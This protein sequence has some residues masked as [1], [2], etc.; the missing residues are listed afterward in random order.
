[1]SVNLR[2]CIFTLV[3]ANLH[4]LL[5]SIRSNAEKNINFK[6]LLLRETYKQF[7]GNNYVW[8]KQNHYFWEQ[9]AGPESDIF[10]SI[11]DVDQTYHKNGVTVQKVVATVEIP[12]PPVSNHSYT[13]NSEP[14]SIKAGT[15]LRM[16]S[17][18]ERNAENVLYLIIFI[19][20]RLSWCQCPANNLTALRL[21]VHLWL[22]TAWK[23][24]LLMTGHL[25]DCNAF[26]RSL[27]N[28]LEA[29]ILSGGF[30]T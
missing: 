20:R 12:L 14:A 1:M 25:N 10:P 27:C 9:R 16:V 8:K 30:H 28:F 19:F 2:D 6:S 23:S 5:L 26:P 29:I 18:H 11:N 22:W 17:L 13:M 4:Y 24:G 3:Q 21:S 15:L 7:I